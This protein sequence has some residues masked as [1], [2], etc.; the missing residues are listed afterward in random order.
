MPIGNKRIK[1]S[2]LFLSHSGYFPQNQVKTTRSESLMSEKVSIYLKYQL[3]APSGAKRGGVEQMAPS[4][5]REIT[6][7]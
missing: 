3:I 5:G 6:Y 4:V 2:R 7:F 1:G